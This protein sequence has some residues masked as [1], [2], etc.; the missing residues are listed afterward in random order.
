M[1]QKKFVIDGGFQVDM[2]SQIDADLI[3][4]GNIL[5]TLDDV[6]DLG[7]PSLRFRDLYLGPGSLYINN[8]KVI[9][10]HSDTIMISTDE[11][12]SMTVKTSGTG[13][14]TF[15]SAQTINFAGTLQMAAGKR[16]TDAGGNSV[17]FG[18]KVDMDGNRVVNMGAPIN[19]FD[20]STKKYVDDKFD[21][22]VGNA[23]AALDTLNELANALG[24]D[25]NFATTVTT[26]LSTK[27]NSTAVAA[28]I[29]TAL[30]TASADA[31][32]KADAAQS[33][34]ES[35]SATDATT[36]AN[37]AKSDAISAAAADATTKA[38]AA[39]AA[40]IAT[41]DADATTKANLA[42]TY[43]QNNA[44]T[45]A[46]TKA[47]AAV[48]S[49]QAY[50]DAREA[51]ITSAFQAYT[52]SSISNNVD[53]TGYATET[54]VDAAVAGVVESAPGAL[55][56]LNE[57]A[58]AM[59]DDA[60]FASTVV[61]NIATAK[62]EAISSA[63]A[64]TDARETAITNNYN[65]A[66]S[67]ESTAI[68]N[69]Y[70]TAIATAIATATTNITASYESYADNAE[71]DA[72][73]TASADA[74]SKASAAQ[75]AAISAAA[76]DASTKASAAQT[77]AITAA[78]SDATTKATA[79]QN[80]AVS[81]A[82]SDATTKANA[83]QSAAQSYADTAAANAVA[84]AIDSAPGALDTLNELAAAL[85]DDENFASTVTN[86]IA[87]AKGEAISTASADATTKA[88]AAQSAAISAAASDATT[89]AN[90]AQASAEA[91]ASA[92]ATAKANAAQASAEATA[93]ADATAKANA[94]V[95]S[96]V[97]TA[98][99]DASSKANAALSSAQSYADSAEA[100][101]IAT[102][103]AD[104]TAKANAALASA[105]AYADSAVS[106]VDLSGYATETYVDSAVAGVVNSAPAALDTLNELAAAL[107]D[108]A[109]FA[110][111]MTSSLAGK[112]DN[113]GDTM[114][115]N[116][117][118][119]SAAIE[120]DQAW[121]I[122]W[123]DA[124]TYINGTNSNLYANV[125]GSRAFTVDAN[126]IYNGANG[127][128]KLAT[129]SYVDTEIA[130]ISGGSSVTI[131]STAPTGA[132]AGDMWWDDEDGLLN[133]YYDGAWV[134]ASPQ[135]ALSQGAGSGLDAD[136]LDG[137]QASEFVLANNTSADM[138]AWNLTT[139]GTAI[140]SI[141]IGNQSSTAN[142][143]PAITFGARD[144]SNGTNA[145]A[146]IYINSDGSYGTKM[147]LA[148][149][150]SYATGS[151][152]SVVIDHVGNMVVKADV[153]AYSDD[154][155]KTNVQPIQGALGKVEQVTGVTFERIEDGSV[156]TGVVAQELEAVLPEA[157]KT[158]D[159]GLKHVAYGNITG[160]L[161]EAVK[162]LS[163]EV[164]K[165]KGE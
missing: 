6:Y 77:A 144:A 10:D 21:D 133:V 91:T 8:K 43:A 1:S 62:S 85:G 141:H 109:N 65:V 61:N 44:S 9:S 121:Q 117:K 27:A 105:Q 45:D 114:T 142:A 69:A 94:A 16:I 119:S 152:G 64:Y 99:A 84:N 71:T 49:A 113:S 115:G 70:A 102:A 138:V 14:L 165:L 37:N 95:A 139:P 86:N 134:E 116:L 76:A 22:V 25:A 53:F 159:S 155:L 146:G 153:T 29:A 15:Q 55:D 73:A 129:E 57:L 128:N 164:K 96:A 13:V 7:S 34:A 87:T 140:G 24:D 143:G 83:A 75:T 67:N 52:D 19:D 103:S 33:A 35:A 74:S 126:G 150:S 81:I 39:Q 148:T 118:M 124:S 58:A 51:A 163:A 82:A 145:Q 50:T 48:A 108:D 125:A 80:N 30:A 127:V 123:G 41:A 106:S 161:I 136:L 132:S 66:I 101:A 28:D 92:D 160:L 32:A 60:N 26:T 93:S 157:V 89:K 68:A 120:L 59:G 90:A 36:K 137:Y 149:T 162:E 158:D 147:V 97:A 31:T 156:S 47:N 122:Q 12:Q 4:G 154:S 110:S 131:S 151:M 40:A 104:A 63:S 20:A 42:Q 78:Q 38:N 72:I 111:T 18:D 88:N 5:P 112:L 135:A 3:M 98:S 11:D 23:P 54:Y 100:D 2:E 130:N 46:T 79:A 107:G 17:T 56:T